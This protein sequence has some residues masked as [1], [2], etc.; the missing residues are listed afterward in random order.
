MDVRVVSM[1]APGQAD[2]LDNKD[3]PYIQAVREVYMYDKLRA[4]HCCE[5]TP[6]YELHHIE[7]QVLFT[8]R[9]ERLCERSRERLYEKYGQAPDDP[10]RYV[11]CHVMDRFEEKIKH[12]GEKFRLHVYGDSEVPLDDTPYD[13]QIE[14]LIEHF[15]C[16]AVL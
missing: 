2:W 14:S 11:H 8:P 13:E 9:G 5:L 7:S 3:R 12:T 10:V 16:N 6:S 4:V 15:R 1:D